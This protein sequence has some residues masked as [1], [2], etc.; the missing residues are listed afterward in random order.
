MNTKV[1]VS[2]TPGPSHPKKDGLSA[3]KPKV[4]KHVA[5]VRAD[6]PV[7]VQIIDD[8]KFDTVQGPW[9]YWPVNEIDKEHTVRDQYGFTLLTM[10]GKD[11]P[12]HIEKHARLIAAAPE[13]LSALEKLIVAA[14]HDNDEG[15]PQPLRDAVE[16]AELAL[17]K[18]KGE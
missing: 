3:K 10:N 13:L 1:K 9:T 18:A 16:E 4:V 7:Q 14:W 8:E 15:L 2:H 11:D 6:R 5:F 17:N 12:D